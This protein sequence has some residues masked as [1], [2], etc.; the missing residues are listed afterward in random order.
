M[1][2]LRPKLENALRRIE[3]AQA[4]AWLAE[5][6]QRVDALLR[7]ERARAR[8]AATPEPAGA[9]RPSLSA[10]LAEMRARPIVLPCAAEPRVS[11][12][13]PAY[14]KVEYT[15]ACLRSIEEHCAGLACEVL[16]VDDASPDA[17][18]ALAASATGLRL[19]RNE[20]N[21]GFIGSCNRGLAEARGEFVVFLNNDTRVHAGWLEWLLATF[22]RT[23]SAGLVG[24]KLIYPDGRLQEAGGI[25]FRDGSAWNYGRLGDPDDDRYDYLRD[26][27]YCSGA[28]IMLRRELLLEL[29]G[30]DAHFAPAYYEDTDL[31]F[32]V[33][34]AGLRVL[35]QPLSRVTHF[36]GVTSGTDVGAGVKRYQVVN[37]SKFFE[38][39]RDVLA[40]A[41]E[42]GVDIERQK[43]RRVRRRVLVIDSYI[44]LPDQDSG[45]RRM[46]AIMTVLQGLG[47]KVTFYPDIQQYPEPYASALRARGIEVIT[48]AHAKSLRA[49]LEANGAS[50]DAVVVSRADVATAHLPDVLRFCPQARVAF[51]TVDLHYVREERTAELEN[52]AA[53][54]AGAA[55][56][57]TQ[58][59]GL[60]R[61]V[62]VTWVVSENE[63]RTL[64]AENPFLNVDVVSNVHRIAGCRRPFDARTGVLFVGGYRHPPNVDAIRWFVANIWPEVRT[65]LPGVVLHVAGSEPPPEVLALAC[66]DIVVHGWV[67]DLEPLL[68]A[69]RVSVAP[70]RV[71][72]GVKGK[73]NEAM[74][75][76]L[77][78][79]ATTVASEGMK[80]AHGHDVLVADRPAEFA[81]ALVRLH[82]DRAL[83]EKLSAGGLRNVREHF[84][85]DVARAALVR[86]LEP[87][88]PAEPRPRARVLAIAA[89]GVQLARFG[90][91]LRTRRDDRTNGVHDVAGAPARLRDAE[92][93]REAGIEAFM[94]LYA[95]PPATDPAFDVVRAG[96]PDFP[97]CFAWLEQPERREVLDAA[98][99]SLHFEQL[100][101]ALADPRAV[102]VAGRPLFAIHR[103][104]ARLSSER[105]RALREQ[106]L[107][108]GLPG[109]YL[110][111]LESS[112]DGSGDP[113]ARGFDAIAEL[114][115]DLG[116]LR[117]VRH[118]RPTFRVA[119][120]E[121]LRGAMSEDYD[122]LVPAL[123]GE[124]PS[125]PSF[126]GVCARWDD[127]GRVD[128]R[129]LVLRGGP[130]A[131]A[132]W[133]EAAIARVSKRTPDFRII[134]LDS[135]DAPDSGL[136]RGP[137]AGAEIGYLEATRKALFG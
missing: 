126:P 28:S 95:G 49:H 92:L 23:P 136:R 40:S 120:Q 118:A 115:P 121:L 50:Y 32:R 135:W 134:V 122:A 35:M 11:I 130:A 68:D 44:P 61:Q 29:G 12:V 47:D 128:E 119:L 97:F 90:F 111:S 103:G 26:V 124:E 77:P 83:W 52:D 57:K 76:G 112:G 63:R 22:D 73:V 89:G 116:R 133:L 43:E 87:A 64:L 79:V 75:Y 100:L 34:R 46:D 53:K 30:F 110:V 24:S 80:L 14:G 129:G 62:D 66:E 71:G 20:Q 93:A 113:R 42:R 65:R 86:S 107:G 56:R 81:E 1:R 3:L 37:E 7:P 127:A 36:E 137:E 48:T 85:E 25:V 88:A 51:D 39:W 41:G 21:L 4:K 104:R 132:R 55:V 105:V 98:A 8:A 84:G 94:H 54:R 19:L 2:R 60:A 82:E 6:G 70:L 58:E 16:V 78:V 91:A 99:L 74:S 38:R 18:D 114:Q 59:L 109:L 10:T 102:R 108:A 72:A 17:T 31:A 33:R 67:R 45:S 131:Y 96:A 15:W 125:T 117:A 106:A 9:P 13:I 123:A 27:D 69:C 101:P 5:R